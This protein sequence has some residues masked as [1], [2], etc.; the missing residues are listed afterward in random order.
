MT[1]TLQR[2]MRPHATTSV[3]STTRSTRREGLLTGTSIDR[4]DPRYGAVIS[5]FGDR[6][7]AG[8]SS[9]N[10]PHG[11]RARGASPQEIAS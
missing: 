6:T 3:R 11:E 2:A 1:T 5:D 10:E 4:Q 8:R 9:A 7:T